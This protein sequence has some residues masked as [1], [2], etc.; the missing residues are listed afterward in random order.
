VHGEHVRV[1]ELSDEEGN[2]LLRIG[3]RAIARARIV[4]WS[5]QG[6][7]EAQIAKI[8]S[9]PARRLPRPIPAGSAPTDDRPTPFGGYRFNLRSGD[10]NRLGFHQ[11][12]ST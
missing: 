11:A 7:D 1:R 9:P 5:A 2:Q 10:L 8:A 6:V 4:L 3:L 12:L